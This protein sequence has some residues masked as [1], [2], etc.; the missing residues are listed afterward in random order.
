MTL[1]GCGVVHGSRKPNRR[2][3]GSSNQFQKDSDPTRIPQIT[4]K[5]PQKGGLGLALSGVSSTTE[6]LYY[7]IVCVWSGGD[8]ECLIQTLRIMF[9]C[10]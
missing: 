5:I 1:L 7:R 4:R 10:D 2:V 3:L 8:Q 9:Y 6:L